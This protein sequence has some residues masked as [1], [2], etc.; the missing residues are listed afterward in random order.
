VKLSDFDRVVCVCVDKRANEWGRLETQLASRNVVMEK[1]IVGEGKILPK[2]LYNQID[3]T[4]SKPGYEGRAYPCFISHKNIIKKAKEDNLKNILM[5]ED[6]CEFLPEFDE[7][8]EKGS[9]QLEKAGAAWD[10]L[11]LGANHTWGVTEKV[12]ENLLRLRGGSYCWHAIAIN[13]KYHDMFSYLLNLPEIHLYDWLTAHYTQTSPEFE[14]Y[15][16]WPNAAIQRPGVSFLSE[17]HRDYTEWFT[18]MGT[19]YK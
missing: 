4:E 16:L 19:N 1:F 17:R 14:C 9:K 15:A 2:H 7:I 11:Y 18:N 3:P 6:D 8:L 12:G 13:Q 10:L 5:L